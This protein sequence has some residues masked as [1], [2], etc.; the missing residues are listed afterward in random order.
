MELKANEPKFNQSVRTPFG[1]GRCGGTVK[2]DELVLYL[3]R[4][5]ITDTTKLHRYDSNCL[6]P[7][8]QLSG[9]WVFQK[10]ELQS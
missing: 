7:G 5:P 1:Q 2:H 3:I 8:A 10:S 9:L 4:M 6:T